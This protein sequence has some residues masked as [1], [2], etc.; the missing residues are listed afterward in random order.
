MECA[1]LLFKRIGFSSLMEPE[2]IL[3]HKAKFVLTS[4]PPVDAATSGFQNTSEH[5]VAAST[6]FRG[7]S[8]LT[9]TTTEAKSHPGSGPKDVLS[10]DACRCDA[11]DIGV[12][13]GCRR[14][15]HNEFESLAGQ[16]RSYGSAPVH[17]TISKTSCKPEEGKT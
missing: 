3:R 2:R 9:T 11:E 7:H 6:N 8:E 1:P 16:L 10:P 14:G 13:L 12:A 17:D 4:D 5:K 15:W